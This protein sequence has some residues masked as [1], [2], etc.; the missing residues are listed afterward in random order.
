VAI[1]AIGQ[2]PSN[3]TAL[4]SAGLGGAPRDLELVAAEEIA[5]AVA[6]VLARS[7]SLDEPTLAW[8]TARV[9]GITRL[10]RKVEERMRAGIELLCAKGIAARTGE[11]VVRR[12]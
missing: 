7:L 8:E 3:W 6:W 10:G 1:R 9:F 12:G 4:R 11:R 2:D 5:V